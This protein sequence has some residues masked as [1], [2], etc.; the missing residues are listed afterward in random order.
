[1]LSDRD[2]RAVFEAA[3]DAVLIVDANGMI[4][5]VNPRALAM[6]GWSR[7]EMEG[8]RVERLI[9][10]AARD[11][12]RQHRQNYGEAPRLRPMGQGL[13]LLAL[14]RDG[15][16]IPVEICLSPGRL[17]SG[18]EHVVCTV[19][20]ITDWKRLPDPSTTMVQAAENERKRLSRELHDGL[21]QSLGGSR[22]G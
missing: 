15:T 7:E 9:P 8:S 21:L 11:Q 2:Y 20:E 16:T 6:F 1:M 19:R 22:S 17:A 4:R 5:D 12:H 13:E 18:R 3:P 14:R 10:A